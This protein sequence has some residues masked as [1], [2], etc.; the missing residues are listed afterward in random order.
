[1]RDWLR[2][3]RSILQGGADLLATPFVRV[4]LGLLSLLFSAA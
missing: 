4:G 3:S 1:M 2:L